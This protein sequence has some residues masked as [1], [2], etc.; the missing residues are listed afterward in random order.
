MYHRLIHKNFQNF[1][2]IYRERVPRKEELTIKR[3][4]VD[5]K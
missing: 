4:R 5:T 2:F 1:R 3:G